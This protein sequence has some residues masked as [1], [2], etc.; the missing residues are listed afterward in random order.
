MLL[1]LKNITNSLMEMS[2]VKI[3]RKIY[4]Y[5][6]F[7]FDNGQRSLKFSKEAY[8]QISLLFIEFKNEIG[9]LIDSI[10][11]LGKGNLKYLAMKLDFNDYY[12]D[13]ANDLNNN[14]NNNNDFITNE[15]YNSQENNEYN[16]EL[17][18]NEVHIGAPQRMQYN[19]NNE[20]DAEIDENVEL[21]DKQII[22]PTS[23]NLNIQDASSS[24]YYRPDISGNRISFGDFIVNT[25]INKEGNNKNEEN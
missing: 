11:L 24:I 14:N 7:S 18:N 19:S 5:L 3:L 23:I 20:L 22:D 16:D 25:N 4:I 10:K 13:R 17:L 8:D 15:Y 6:Y 21:D 9:E 12:S 2:K 1:F